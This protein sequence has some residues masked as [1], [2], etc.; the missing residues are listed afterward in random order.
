VTTT[1]ALAPAE[2]APAQVAAEDA[3]AQQSAV[4]TTPL[5]PA[6]QPQE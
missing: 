2:D 4:S 5:L 6:E 3:P 1:A